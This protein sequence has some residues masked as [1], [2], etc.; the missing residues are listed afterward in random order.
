MYI[1]L[2]T[3]LFYE[4]QFLHLTDIIPLLKIGYEGQIY[5]EDFKMEEDFSCHK[6][7][8]GVALKY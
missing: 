4:M 6:F 1:Y 3:N 2:T 8:V 7:D 5:L